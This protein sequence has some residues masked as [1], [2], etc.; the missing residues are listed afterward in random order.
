MR[1][2]LVIVL[3]A[4]ILSAADKTKS[5]ETKTKVHR[6][7]SQQRSAFDAFVYINRIPEKTMD[8]ELPE[9]FA[10]RIYGR[11]ANQ[12]GRILLK[13]PPTMD[14]KAYFGFKTFLGSEGDAKV[15]NCVSCHSSPS[16]TDGK[17]HVVSQG[18]AAKPTPSLR[19]SKLS[20]ADLEKVV[21]EKMALSKLK[22]SGGAPKLAE[23]YA[24]IVITDADVANLVAF[25][26]TLKDV[27]DKRFREL[28]ID[29]KVFDA[30]QPAPVELP[31]TPPVLSGVVR[32]EG[33]PPGRRRLNMTSES[34]RLYQKMPLDEN[35]LV[36][37]NGGLAN[38]FVY[39]KRGVERK[40]Y[41]VPE[42]PAL[43]D[44]QKSMFRPRIQGV[45]VGQKFIIRNSDP[46]IHNTRSLS[47]RNRMFN[48]GQPPRSADRERVF[49]RAEGP[50][51]LGC[52]FHKWMAAWIF[53]VDHPFFAVTD[54][55]GNFEI[56]GLPRGDY[57][58][59]AWHEEY[60]DQ[61]LKVTTAP[62]GKTELN[63]EF[64][65]KNQ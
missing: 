16:F 60:G 7:A 4:T 28:I 11:L 58:L 51:S 40:Q 52:D 45:R 44:Q 21:R 3:G 31:A 17:S 14:R 48:V 20:A 22:K 54:A 39:A 2:L 65:S 35:V 56:K 46:Y 26:A 37:K 9:D 50:I 38:V 57:T 32:L 62:S 12:E 49:K 33:K 27:D 23:A 42:K 5:I 30:T 18:G 6:L 63:F 19:N 34:A 53:V 24:R 25:L 55:N 43:L 41:S 59:E 61:R 1:T 8:G 15:A 36:G 47:L 13:L 64:K 29:A 10:G